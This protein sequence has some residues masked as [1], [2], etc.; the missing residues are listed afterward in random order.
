MRIIN[1]C[2]KFP[3]IYILKARRWPLHMSPPPGAASSCWGSQFGWVGRYRF[4]VAN[5]FYS[6][7]E[8]FK[9]TKHLLTYVHYMFIDCYH[10]IQSRDVWGWREFVICVSLFRFIIAKAMLYLNILGCNGWTLYRI[11]LSG[12]Q[13]VSSGQNGKGR[14]WGWNLVAKDIRMF[15]RHDASHTWDA[16]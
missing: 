12:C 7:I 16:L 1:Q 11:A 14:R 10:E 5:C 15:I 2:W 3:T 6:M 4:L 9:V 8:S 13:T